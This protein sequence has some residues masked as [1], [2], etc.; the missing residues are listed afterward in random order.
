MPKA[1]DYILPGLDAHESLIYSSLLLHG[2]QAAFSLAKQTKL[3]RIGTRSALMRLLKRGVVSEQQ[4][5][6]RNLYV[7]ENPDFLRRE[8]EMQN[9][10][11]QVDIDKLVYAQQA[12]QTGGVT[13]LRGAAE[14]QTLFIDLVNSLGREEVF[15]RYIACGSDIDVE[16]FVPTSYRPTRDE[17]SIQQIAITSTTMRGRPY[18]KGMGCLWKILPANEEAFTM[19]AGQIIYGNKIAFI[20]YR[21]EMAYIFQSSSVAEMLKATHRALY[22]RLEDRVT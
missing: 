20:D 4:H 17:K 18:K 13:V 1:Q 2:P 12:R 9:Q 10:Q 15:Y 21:E 22:A 14:I 7:A 16:K 11:A 8:L 6:K 19:G 5:G 3:H